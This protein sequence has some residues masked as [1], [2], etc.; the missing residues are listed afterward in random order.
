MRISVYSIEK[1]SDDFYTKI[2][3]KEKKMIRKYAQIEEISIFDKKISKAQNQNVKIAQES[4]SIALR[5]YLKGYNI[6]LDPKG[7]ELDSFEFSKIFGINTAINFF[8]G[9]A[10]GF[11]ESFLEEFDE[12]VSLSRLTF[13]HKIAKV[14][15]FEQIYRALSI[16]NN[17]PYHK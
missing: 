11:E 1:K 6:A 2:V 16:K 9:G 8:I 12:V 14:V 10:Y 17:H 7:K 4:Y 3:E 15:L 5:T 13:S